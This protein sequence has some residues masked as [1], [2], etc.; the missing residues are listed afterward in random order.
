MFHLSYIGN[1]L[2]HEGEG[3]LL[4]AL[5]EKGW[6]EGLS[7]GQSLSLKGQAMFGVNIRLTEDGLANRDAVVALVFRYIELIRKEGIEPVSYTHL[8]LPTKA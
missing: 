8:T 3:S 7:A 5:K 1:L 2:G 4:S 6:A